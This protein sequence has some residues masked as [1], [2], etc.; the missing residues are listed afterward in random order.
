MRSQNV[1][2]WILGDISVELLDAAFLTC[3]WFT[4]LYR[5]LTAI[6]APLAPS[7][8][9]GNPSLPAKR[10][11]SHGRHTPSIWSFACSPWK[12]FDAPPRQE[13]RLPLQHFFSQGFRLYAPCPNSLATSVPRSG[14]SSACRRLYPSTNTRCTRV[15]ALTEEEHLTALGRLL[16]KLPVHPSVG[17]MVMLGVIFCCLEP[18]IILGAGFN[19][20]SPFVAPIGERAAA[21]LAH[22]PFFEGH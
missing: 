6:I 14:L 1:P 19:E 20:R 13:R 21:N 10:S 5:Y 9:P 22:E 11:T 12:M 18:M 7:L 8:P 3:G 15:Q 17:K 2:H 4:Q 16:A